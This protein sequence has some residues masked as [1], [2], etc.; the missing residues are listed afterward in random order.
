MAVAATSASKARPRD[1]RFGT[2]VLAHAEVTDELDALFAQ[3]DVDEDAGAIAR[4]VDATLDEGG[5]RGV[6][7]ALAAELCR[8]QEAVE[9]GDGFDEEAAQDAGHDGQREHVPESEL[10]GAVEREREHADARDESDDHVLH[11][12]RAH[13]RT[14][15]DDDLGRGHGFDRC[16]RCLELSFAFFGEELHP[17]HQGIS[18]LHLVEQVDELLNAFFGERVVDAGAHAADRAV[19]AQPRHASR[20]G[21]LDQL[22]FELGRGP[23]ERDV[24]L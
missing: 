11:D 14:N 24:H 22:V 4:R 8:K 7:D 13:A 21:A 9:P 5:T 10:D 15:R 3:R 2:H 19:A 6:V 1:E 18:R 20:F 23:A 12:R 16:H 17:P